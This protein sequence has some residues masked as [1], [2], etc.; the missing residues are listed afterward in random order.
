MSEMVVKRLQDVVEQ[1]LRPRRE[2]PGFAF[3]GVIA[4]NNANASQ[5]FGQ[6]TADFSRDL[7]PLAE[8]GANGSEGALQYRAEHDQNQQHERSHLGAG[9]EEQDGGNNRGEQAASEFHQSGSDK[10]THAFDVAHDP[11]D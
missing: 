1:A 7:A 4:L 10:V 8:D 3:F 2:H 5:C 6:A 11:R 9:A